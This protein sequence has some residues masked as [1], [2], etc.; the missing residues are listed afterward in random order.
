MLAANTSSSMEAPSKERHPFARNV[1]DK[2]Y[3]V[4]ACQNKWDIS[5]L[6]AAVLKECGFTVRQSVEK[7]A[8]GAHKV[9]AGV[10]GKGKIPFVAE[11]TAKAEYE[12]NRENGETETFVPLELDPFDPNDIIRALNDIGF[13]KYVVLE[14]F[15]YLPDTT[16]RDFSFS[17]KTF[18]ESSKLSFIVVG[19]WREENRL[20]GFNG[21]LT[22]RVLSVDVDTW[23]SSSLDEVMTVGGELLNVQ[24]HDDFKKDILRHCFDSVH[25]VQEACRRVCRTSGI[26]RTSD[27]FKVI[28]ENIDVTNLIAAV[29]SEQAARYKGFLMGFSDG[30][31][32]TD[33]EMPKWIIFSILCSDVDQLEKGIRLRRISK[34]IKSRHPKGADLNNGNI[35]QILNSSASLQ[36]RKGTRPLVV[37]YDSANT[38]LNVVDKGFL[39]WLS[40]QNIDEI[41]EDLGMPNK[42]TPVELAAL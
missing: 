28:G 1:L 42:L 3:V 13:K 18:H 34:I 6:H 19:V 31:Q 25:I 7:T 36:N 16:Q 8:S 33:L 9:V 37:D 35:T 15:H 21:D 41:L 12:H 38:S 39:I 10:E 26:T 2:D 22:D 29:V 11:A 40:S 24:F 14:D 17:L 27:D 30:F 5:E 4:V 23:I 32:E 20:I